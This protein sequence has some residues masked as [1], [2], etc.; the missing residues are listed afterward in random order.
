MN[1]WKALGFVYDVLFAIAIPTVLLAL[2]GRWLDTR[3]HVAPLF[4]LIGLALALA[5]VIVLMMRKTK[6][7]KK[8]MKK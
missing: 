2:A 3:W 5:V 4:S 6:Q 7:L 1:T 8:L